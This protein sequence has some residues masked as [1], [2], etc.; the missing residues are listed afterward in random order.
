ME[1]DCSDW[2][3]DSESE[4]E[5]SAEVIQFD[6]KEKNLLKEVGFAKKRI[7]DDDLKMLVN[8]WEMIIRTVLKLNRSKHAQT[9]QYLQDSMQETYLYGNNAQKWKEIQNM[10]EQKT[11][12]KQKQGKQEEILSINDL[13]IL[14]IKCILCILC[15]GH[16]E[17]CKQFLD[18]KYTQTKPVQ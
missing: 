1:D 8:C 4:S 18:D 16:E 7:V 2:R 11:E 15:I 17:T 13:F 3:S 5:N 6:R 14:K 9:F 10:L 12:C